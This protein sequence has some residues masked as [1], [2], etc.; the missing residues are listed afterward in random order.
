MLEGAGPGEKESKEEGSAEGLGGCTGS[1]WFELLCVWVFCLCTRF[2]Q[3]PW[4][5]EEGTGSPVSTPSPLPER[6]VAPQVSHHSSPCLVLHTESY[7]VQASLTLAM[8]L[9]MTL[10]LL[11][12][13]RES[14]G[15]IDLQV[16]PWKVF[17]Q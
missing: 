8:E 15:I 13:A 5:P 6:P 12:A 16:L 7:A 4:K 2:L 9:R 10:V 14:A 3:S 1:V 17:M 11:L